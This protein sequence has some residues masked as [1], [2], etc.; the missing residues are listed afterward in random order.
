[1]KDWLTSMDAHDRLTFPNSQEARHVA[2]DLASLGFKA[3][4]IQAQRYFV[5]PN[6]LVGRLR[7]TLELGGCDTVTRGLLEALVRDIE[8]GYPVDLAKEARERA[9]KD[10]RPDP[11]QPKD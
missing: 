1:M 8:S 4:F 6:L 7:D 11:A 9:I 3:G 5:N 10:F 2:R